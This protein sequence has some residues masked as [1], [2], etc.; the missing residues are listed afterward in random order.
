[1]QVTQ[2][3]S[4]QIAFNMSRA[5]SRAM[6]NIGHVAATLS[7]WRSRRR[8]RQAL[9]KLEDHQLS[10]IGITKAEALEEANKPFWQGSSR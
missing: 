3:Y 6:A 9:R 8:E 5:V 4:D 2:N 10:D 7:L 1:M